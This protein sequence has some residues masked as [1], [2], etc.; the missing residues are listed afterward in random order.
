MSELVRAKQGYEGMNVR[1]LIEHLQKLIKEDKINPDTKLVVATDDGDEPLNCIQ[2][3]DYKPQQLLLN[4]LYE[5]E[6]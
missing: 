1:E 5:S 2:W 3:A 6:F 4:S